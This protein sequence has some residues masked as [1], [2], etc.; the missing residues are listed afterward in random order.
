MS[1]GTT[2]REQD[3]YDR[4]YLDGKR[5]G[6]HN[7][8]SL[9][10]AGPDAIKAWVKDYKARYPDSKRKPMPGRS[11]TVTEPPATA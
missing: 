5:D 3:C 6:E 9:I 7:T 2:K 10:M 4:G 11:Y 8:H 1:K